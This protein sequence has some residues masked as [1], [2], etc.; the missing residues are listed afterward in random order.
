MPYRKKITL[1]SFLMSNIRINPKWIRN[2]N[3][4]KVAIQVPKENVVEFLCSL[5]MG[6]SFLAMTQNP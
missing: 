6:K 5:G 2:V 3:V 4:K 1:D